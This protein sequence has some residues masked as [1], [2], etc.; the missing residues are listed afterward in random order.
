MQKALTFFRVF[1]LAFF[2]PGTILLIAGIYLFGDSSP[3]A[4]SPDMFRITVAIF[5]FVAAAFCIGLVVHSFVWCSKSWI[6]AVFRRAGKSETV[7]SPNDTL[8]FPMRFKGGPQE[9]LILYFWYLRAT[10]WNIAC[11]LSLILIY[12]IFAGENLPTQLQ[13]FQTVLMVVL[14]ASVVV[15]VRQ[16][17]EFQ[18]TV[19][20]SFEYLSIG[21][22]PKENNEDQESDSNS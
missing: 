21:S 20:A 5:G 11:S 22:S 7:S 17:S 16:G 1:D 8:P 10:C 3:S 6:E 4:S 18:R 15:L 13:E 19:Y 14:A 9:D 2:A 12:L